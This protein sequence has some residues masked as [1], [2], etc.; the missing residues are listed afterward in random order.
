MDVTCAGAQPASR[1]FAF[2]FPTQSEALSLFIHIQGCT[3]SLACPGPPS[4]SP[5]HALPPSMASQP[6][7]RSIRRPTPRCR[8]SSYGP[9]SFHRLR[10]C[11]RF[12]VGDHFGQA[13]GVCDF[14][15][16]M[17]TYRVGKEGTWSSVGQVVDVVKAFRGAT[18]VWE[19]RSVRHCD[20]FC[21][22]S[23]SH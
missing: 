22:P 23:C 4:H 13:E 19:F 7:G 9:G 11:R 15:E 14:V 16:C 21:S 1:T 2:F 5:S 18:L 6:R 8:R 3:A 17:S 10:Y 12:Y 20:T